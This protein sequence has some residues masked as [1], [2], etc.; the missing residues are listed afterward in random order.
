[1]E[2]RKMINIKYNK[3]DLPFEMVE[4]KGLGHPDTLCDAIAEKTSQLYSKFCYKKY[5]KIAHHWFDKVMLIG[6]ESDIS[7]G[8][9]R[10][11][12]PYRLIFAGKCAKKICGS[13]VPLNEIFEEA[14]RS[15]LENYLTEFDINKHLIIVDETVDHQGT[16]RESKRYRPNSIEDLSDITIYNKRSN[17]CNLLAAH[18]PLTRLENIVYELENFI[19]NMEYKNKYPMVGWDVKIVGVRDE[20]DYE[21]VVNV[22]VLAKYINS[23]EDY[24][25]VVEIVRCDLNQMILSNYDINYDLIINPQDVTGQPYITVFGSAADT[26][27]VGVVG[28]GNRINGLITPMQPMSIEASAGKNVIDHTGKLYASLSKKLSK[29]ISLM[30]EQPVEIFIYTYKEVLLVNPSK[31]NIK[32]EKELSNEN[33]DKILNYVEQQLERIDEIV[34]EYI[35]KGAVLW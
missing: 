19:N 25:S 13:R 26:G 3:R 6:G 33:K 24:D 30:I 15:I 32:L 21:I 18:Y 4:R 17:D 2:V 27:D 20:E 9:G 31:I 29:D 7:Y 11:I 5:N 35:F 22:P 28:R 23:R 16:G 12:K 14:A 8:F 34:H 10:L 1:M